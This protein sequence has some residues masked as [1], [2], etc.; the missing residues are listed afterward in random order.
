MC[1]NRLIESC[2]VLQ[3]LI[4]R[5]SS[6]LYLN[7]FHQPTAALRNQNSHLYLNTGPYNPLFL[8]YFSTLKALEDSLEG[9]YS[10]SL[11]I[12]CPFFRRRAL[13]LIDSL[14]RT[15]Q[16][17]VVR[18]KSIFPV[19][20]KIPGSSTYYDERKVTGLSMD[21]ISLIIE[22]DWN[23]LHS[24]GS[25]KPWGDGKGYYITGKLSYGIYKDECIFD[26]T[27]PDMPVV[28]LRKYLSAASQLFDRKKSRADLICPLTININ[29]RTIVARWRLQGILNLPWH[30]SIK[31]MTGSTTYY[32]SEDGMVEK[33]LEQWDITVIDAFISVLFKDLDF[34]APPAKPL[35]DT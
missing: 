25:S 3:I 22:K 8:S 18:H 11:R 19:S 1:R 31:P 5:C 32:I 13:D 20:I 17:I 33:H 24:K 28:G 21:Q 29:E 4:L 7:N 26:G 16:F 30:P 10:K 35:D 27:D 15:F 9:T 34:G 2:F 23:A 14:A 12:K 6:Y